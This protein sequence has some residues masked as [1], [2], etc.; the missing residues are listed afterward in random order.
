MRAVIVLLTTLCLAACATTPTVYAPASVTSSGTGYSEVR[1]EADRWRVTFEGAG[2]ATEAEVERF[3]LRRAA[4]LALQ[5]GYEWFEVVDRRINEEG[6]N[7][8]PVRV[9]GSV[10]RSLGSGGLSGT[11]VGLGIALSPGDSR[12]T[13]V[14]I[15]I[16]AGSGEPRPDRAYDAQTVS[17][18]YGAAPTAGEL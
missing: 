6:G 2:D 18:P 4:E 10:G 5:N 17:R 8:N 3:A 15:E 16:I 14:S 13:T 7:R 1:I 9:G 11:S 12:R